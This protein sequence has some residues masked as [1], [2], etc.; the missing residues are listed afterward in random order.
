MAKNNGLELKIDGF[1]D[2]TKKFQNLVDTST[3]LV[4]F[5]CGKVQH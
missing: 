4:I 1:W 3:I 5:V 2:V